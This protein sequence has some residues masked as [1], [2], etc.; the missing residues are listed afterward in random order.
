MKNYST[1]HFEAYSWNPHAG[2]I[3]LRY[4]LDHDIAFEE[5]L[6]LPE[7]V[8]EKILK[9]K[10][11]EIER[12]LFAL[13][14]IG[15]ISYY[16]TCLP[17]EMHVASGAM[18]ASDR[19]FWSAVYENGLG[20]F[21]YVN[22]LDYRGLIRFTG[23]EIKTRR[24]EKRRLA[25]VPREKRANPRILVP[26][27]G[28]K[29]SMVTVELLRKSPANLTLLRMNSNPV[30]DELSYAIGLPMLTV[31]RVL[32][33]NLFD[34]NAEGALNGH[35]PITA[36]LSVVSVLMALLYDFDAIAMSNERSASEGNVEYRGMMINHQWSKSLE[37]EKLFR[38]Y[39]A[40]SIGSDVDYWSAL[41]PFS[42][43]K[44]AEIFSKYPQYFLRT[45]SCNGNWKVDG[46]AA[47]P[48]WCGTCPKCA[49]V[50]ACLAAYLPKAQLQKIFGAILFE[51]EKLLPLF[52][53]LLG[54]ENFKPFECVG[55]PDETK[56]AFLLAAK[57]SDLKDTAV[58]KMFTKEVLP[59]I[60]NPEKLIE[61]VLAATTEHCIPNEFQKFILH[62][63]F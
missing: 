48:T 16:K 13:H 20:E 54:I 57:R 11:W 28:G 31:K 22:N 40:E 39:L 25:P 32:S 62:S 53:E 59:S 24:H 26:L 29:D 15:G 37:F 1:F 21:F 47:K 36:Y 45:T 12:A 18:S 2:K 51:D 17:K 14:L 10:E 8:D 34:L 49:F 33:S 38:R 30:I 46:E 56:A 42:E 41:R 52:R 19:K 61:S 4:T 43:L 3:V 55:T 58:M 6:I 5:T 35:V 50:F 23:E 9:E 63:T 44:I 60:K 7:P 27:G